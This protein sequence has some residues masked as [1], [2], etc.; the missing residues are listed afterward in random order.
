[1]KEKLSRTLG[2]EIGNIEAS[3]KNIIRTFAKFYEYQ[4]SNN[5]NERTDENDS[6]ESIENNCEHDDDEPP[7]K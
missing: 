5:N 4:N 3:K 1:M 6:G 7:D 2:N